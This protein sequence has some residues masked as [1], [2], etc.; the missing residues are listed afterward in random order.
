MS[1]AV[2]ERVEQDLETSDVP[3][4]SAH[5]IMVPPGETDSTPQAYLL[6]SRIEG[7]PVTALCGYTWVPQKDPQALPVCSRCLDIYQQPGEHRDER[8]ELPDA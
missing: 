5:I 8:D 3:G 4:D 6:R 7:S 1:V 2:D